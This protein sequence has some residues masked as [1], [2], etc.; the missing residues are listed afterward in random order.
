MHSFRSKVMC[1]SLLLSA[2]SLPILLRAP[3]LETLVGTHKN[4][5]NPIQRAR[6]QRPMNISSSHSLPPGI[7]L[8]VATTVHRLARPILADETS[9][10]AFDKSDPRPTINT[11][12]NVFEGQSI[13]PIDA[14]ILAVWRH[15][16]SSAGWN[17]RVLNLSHVT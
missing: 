15:A 16:W 1:S 9:I 14:E 13:D 8:E 7:S 17:P 6:K 4:V 10:F 11:F 12:F 3:F 2:V 5:I